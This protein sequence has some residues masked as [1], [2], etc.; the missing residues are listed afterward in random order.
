MYD[1]HNDDVQKLAMIF[2]RYKKA[3]RFPDASVATVISGLNKT[4]AAVE[5]LPDHTITR[6]KKEKTGTIFIVSSFPC[7]LLTLIPMKNG[8]N[9]NSQS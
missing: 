1:W 8:F 4:P 6:K 2:K 5:S 7:Y 3:K 9:L